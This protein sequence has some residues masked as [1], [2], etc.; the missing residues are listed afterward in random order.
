MEVGG[1][2]GRFGPHP[3]RTPKP[4]PAHRHLLH[5]RLGG[6]DILV[7][8]LCSLGCL[9]GF[10]AVP[11]KFTLTLCWGQNRNEEA[12]IRDGRGYGEPRFRDWQEVSRSVNGH[13]GGETHRGWGGSWPDKGDSSVGQQHSSCSPGAEPP[14]R[15]HRLTFSS[16]LKPLS[17]C[18]WARRPSWKCC[19]KRGYRLTWA[20]AE[21]LRK[22][23]GRG[24]SPSF[25]PVS[26]PAS[27]W[28]T[29]DTRGC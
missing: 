7:Q 25:S 21:T 11:L 1:V 29:R 27:T 3:T 9:L 5:V 22:P 17:S 26:S 8:A 16:C 28:P 18:C 20:A 23:Q 12:T 13:A 4:V 6:V 19:G 10:P 14:F 15:T 24:H 2:T